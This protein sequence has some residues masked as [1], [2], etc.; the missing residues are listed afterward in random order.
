MVE[1]INNMMEKLPRERLVVRHWI[2]LFR[3]VLT[4]LQPY[5]IL[6][7]GLGSS[8]YIQERLLEYYRTD[9]Q[10]PQNGRSMEIIIPDEP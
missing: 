4:E 6:S 5:L 10:S 1:I 9:Q 2:L 7:G 8:K 3:L